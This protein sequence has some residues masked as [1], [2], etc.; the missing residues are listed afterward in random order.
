M[1]AR[2]ISIIRDIINM[3]TSAS[4]I[5]TQRRQQSKHRKTQG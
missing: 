1:T 2:R 5:H 4:Q 3:E